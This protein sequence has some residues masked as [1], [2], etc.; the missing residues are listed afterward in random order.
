MKMLKSYNKMLFI[1]LIC[2]IMMVSVLCG[3]NKQ[4]IGGSAGNHKTENNGIDY[5]ALAANYNPPSIEGLLNAVKKS[6]N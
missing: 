2:V 4:T 5:K 3:C 6:N 1:K